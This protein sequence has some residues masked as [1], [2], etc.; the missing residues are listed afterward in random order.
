MR[1]AYRNKKITGVLSV[2][3]KNFKTFDEEMENYNADKSRT[4]RLKLVMGYDRHHLVEDGVTVSDMAVFGMKY[5][6]D[7]GLLSKD[8]ISALVLVTESPDYFLPPTSCVIQGRLGLSQDVFCLDINQGCAGYI[9]GLMEAFSLLAQDD[10]KKV[11]L[12]NADIL[13]RKISKEDRNSYPLA[14]DAIAITIV[15]N[16]DDGSLIQG[17]I[18][19][20]GARHEVLMIPAGGFKM[21]STPETAVMHEDRDG[22]RRSLDNLVMKGREVFHFVQ[23]EMPPLLNGLFDRIGI[24]KDEIDWYLFHQPNKFMVDKLAEELD[25]P[26]EKMPSNIVTNFGNPSGVTVPLNISFN[27]GKRLLN[28]TFKVCLAGF[29]VGLTWGAMVLEIGN[30]NFNDLIEF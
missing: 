11:V 2:V 1:F 21:P 25:V 7:N 13:S 8:D 20:D 17:E 29:G 4:K 24:G 15:E 3:P 10:M 5:L 18:K 9:V 12:I 26:Y 28:E 6:F 16:A 27:I 22:N 30:L 23:T 14:G 19:F